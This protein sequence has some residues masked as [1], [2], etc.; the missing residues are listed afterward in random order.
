[1]RKVGPFHCGGKTMLIHLSVWKPIVG[2]VRDWP[3]A[4]CSAETIDPNQDLEPCDLVYSD[5]VVENMQTYHHDKQRWFYLSDQM[6]N[7]A[8]LFLQ[9]DTQPQFVPGLCISL[10][11]LLLSNLLKHHSTPC[12]SPAA[13]H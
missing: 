5:Y 3:L 10:D 6:P 9:A 1:M 7:E 4:L 13:R 11:L 12:C 8:W 2:P